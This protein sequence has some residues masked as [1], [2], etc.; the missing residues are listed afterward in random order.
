MNKWCL[1]AFTVIIAVAAGCS[2][3]QKAGV[4]RSYSLNN[5]DAVI[6][7]DLISFDKGISSDGKGSIKAEVHGPTTIPLISV[8]DLKI[9]DTR[10]V[11]TARV[12]TEK[13]IG[14]VFLEMIA[15]FP[16]GRQVLTRGQDK[17]LSGTNDWKDQEAAL[18]LLKGSIPDSLRLN[19]VIN[20]RGTVWI[21]D[22][23]LLRAPLKISG[24][25]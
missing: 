13:V 17:L 18:D 25:Q 23:A 19:L 2:R 8:T 22:V 24:A 9:D 7:N 10:L 16:N 6:P 11:Y 12:R 20:G 3:S 1:I 15:Y 4:L 21:D 5:I 14:Q